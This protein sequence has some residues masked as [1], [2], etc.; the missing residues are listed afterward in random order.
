MH[1]GAARSRGRRSCDKPGD[2]SHPA[3][4]RTMAPFIALSE[5]K[6]LQLLG[7]VSQ[8]KDDVNQIKS[9]NITLRN[10]F[11]QLS[12]QFSGQFSWLSNQLGEFFD[13]YKKDR[14]E[15]RMRSNRLDNWNKTQ[16]YH[17]LPSIEVIDSKGDVKT[18]TNV[19]SRV[20]QIRYMSRKRM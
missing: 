10:E 5:D 1:S 7:D 18:P 4:R 2:T 3:H 9:G 19:P 12:G 16:P 17:P 6:Y 8:I 14:D 13:K 11:S 15:D 20:R